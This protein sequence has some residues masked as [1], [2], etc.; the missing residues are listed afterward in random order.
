[1]ATTKDSVSHSGAASSIP[2]KNA[3]KCRKCKQE[4]DVTTNSATSCQHHKKEFVCRYHPEGAK[5][6]AAVEE[7]PKHDKW[8]GHYWDCCGEEDPNAPGCTRGFHEAYGT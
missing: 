6:Y 4:F 8:P 1:M 7:V 3:R 5:Y 2:P